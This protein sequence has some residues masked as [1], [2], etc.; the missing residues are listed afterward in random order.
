M[1]SWWY[2]LERS[3]L[4]RWDGARRG[5][6]TSR[7]GP[8]RVV[9]SA[10]GARVG[11]VLRGRDGRGVV[12][13]ERTPLRRVGVHREADAGARDHEQRRNRRDELE[14]RCAHHVRARHRTPTIP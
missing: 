9:L 13:L 2:L 1:T 4:G 6:V 3:A 10:R 5:P 12:A 7:N 11:A 14:Q 8:G